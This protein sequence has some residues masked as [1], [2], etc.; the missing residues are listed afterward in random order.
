MTHNRPSPTDHLTVELEHAF[1]LQ[2]AMII[3]HLNKDL[4]TKKK[5]FPVVSEFLKFN[6][7]LLEITVDFLNCNIKFQFYF[8]NI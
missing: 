7:I 4:I 1:H 2:K 3:D 5:I 6:F 8:S